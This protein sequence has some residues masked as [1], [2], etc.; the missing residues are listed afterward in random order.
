MFIGLIFVTRLYFAIEESFTRFFKT[1][2]RKRVCIISAVPLGVQNQRYI[3][4]ASP[5]VCV[6][7]ARTIT[8]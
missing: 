8:L 4:M 6:K 5:F 7:R 1:K 2:S 3:F